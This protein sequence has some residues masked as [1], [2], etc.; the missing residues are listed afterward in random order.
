MMGDPSAAAEGEMSERR[1][2]TVPEHPNTL[3][4]VPTHASSK[5]G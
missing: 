2:P 5:F 4:P 1:D 3:N